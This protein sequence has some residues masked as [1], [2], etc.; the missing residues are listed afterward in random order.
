MRTRSLLPILFLCAPAIAGAQTVRFSGSGQLRL[1]GESW[2]GFGAGAPTTADADDAFGLSRLLLRGQAKIENRI[3]L[4]G[5][6]KS[7]LV[8]SRNLPGGTRTADQD[9]LDVQQLY[10]EV[11]GLRGGS[12]RA[13]RFDLALGRERLVSPLDWSNTKRVFQGVLLR[14]VRRQGEL[15]L[16]WVRPVAIRKQQPNFADSLRQL[17]GLQFARG[18]Q[19]GGAEVY[20]LRNQSAVGSF[21]GT[22]GYERRHTFGA[23]VFRKPAANRFDGDVEAAYQAGNVGAGRISAWMVA[24]QFGRTLPGAWGTRVYVGLDAASGDRATGGDVNTFNQLFPLGHAYLGYIDVHGR[25]NVI[26][27]S[28]GVSVKPRRTLT[29][30]LDVHDFHRASTADAVYGTDGSIFRAAGSGLSSSVGTE[31]DLT[32]R[33]ALWSN[34]LQLQGGASRYLA[35]TFLTASGTARDISWVY[36]QA[37][38]NF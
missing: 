16:F 19:A 24:S 29:A 27:A 10:A 3:I 12:M 23:H 8:A 36:L 22:A 7:S 9:V 2:S 33:Q 30:M 18:S 4:F 31:I 13:G 26:D 1:R 25:Q 21:N 5:E 15:T 38:L 34:H 11:A 6:L 37:A 17:Y 20:W 32:V 35:G 14:G 28:A